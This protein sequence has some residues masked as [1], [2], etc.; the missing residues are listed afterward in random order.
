MPIHITKDSDDDTAIDTNQLSTL[1]GMA[2]ISI[3]QERLRGGG[4][5]FFRVGKNGR[6][7]RYRLGDV[8]GWIAAR[9]VVSK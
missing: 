3:V 7:I 2:A 5:P 6:T 4:P 9:T 1:L 8:R